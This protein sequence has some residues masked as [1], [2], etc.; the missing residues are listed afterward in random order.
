MQMN[1]NVVTIGSLQSV[2]SSQSV[3]FQAIVWQQVEAQMAWLT[4]E[5]KQ[6][7]AKMTELRWMYVELLSNIDGTSGPPRRPPGP[8]KDPPLPP[9]P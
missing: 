8:G 4:T 6:L 1:C 3:E 5:T 7:I 2:S 9:P